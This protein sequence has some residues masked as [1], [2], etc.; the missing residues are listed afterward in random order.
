MRRWET[1]ARDP[2]PRASGQ[3]PQPPVDPVQHTRLVQRPAPEGVL[4]LGTQLKQMPAQPIHSPGALGD[5][6]A[7]VIEQ[8]PDLHRLLVQIRDRELLDAV[9]DDRASDRQ[10]VDLIR[11]ARLAL[12]LARGAHPVRRYPHDPLAY[13]QQRLLE[14]ARD[15]PAVLKRPH[16]LP[17]QAPS[18]PDR[19][20]MPRLVSLDLA[21]A[22]N[23][24]GPP[25]HRRQGVRAL[26]RVRTDHDHVHR[27][28][29]W[30]ITDEA[31][32]RRTTV[33]RGECHAPIKSRRRSSGGGGRH[34]LCRSGQAVDTGVESQPAASP[35]TNRTS[36]TSPPKPQGR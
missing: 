14:P 27:P 15:V 21:A 32:L 9:L 3:L 13:G 25:I 22:A 12:A 26:V 2:D 35:R 23:P 29:V 7:S 36:R 5:Q 28:F 18:P 8:Q 30:L 6:I 16:A 10:R 17:I 34:K 4:E 33:T 1:C 20:Q 31:D 24:T 19:G 11:L